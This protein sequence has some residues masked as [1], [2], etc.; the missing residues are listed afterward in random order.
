MDIL[1]FFVK[2]PNIQFLELLN[3]YLTQNNNNNNNMESFSPNLFFREFS[4]V[5]KDFSENE[6]SPLGPG[7]IIIFPSLD[8]NSQKINFQ[9]N[10]YFILFY[11]LGL[12]MDS[13][14]Y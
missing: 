4:V 9:V 5:F 7:N 10:Y 13:S 8:N 6:I 2:D 11:S 12:D 1:I 3:E 14:K